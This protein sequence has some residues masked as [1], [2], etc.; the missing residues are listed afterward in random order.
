MKFSRYNVWA[1]VDDQVGLYNGMSGGMAVFSPAERAVVEGFVAGTDSGESAAELLASLVRMR[2]ITNDDV[3]EVAELRHRY[4]TS[5]WHGGN[6]GY[7]VVTSLGCNFDCPYCF[8]D[9]HPSLLKAEVADALVTVLEDSVPF[10][11]GLQVTWMGG[12]PLLGKRQLLDLSDRFLA[13]CAT[14]GLGYRASII[15]NGWYLDGPTARALAE[16]QVTSA[17]VTIDGPP[18]VHDLKRPRVGGGPTFD[19]IVDNIG[20]AAEHLDVAIRVNVDTANVHR[21]DE[22][23]GVLAATGLAGKVGIGLGKVTDAVSNLASPLASYATGCLSAQRFGE[24]ELAFN[25]RA[26]AHGFGYPGLP[27]PRATPCTAVR[28]REIVVGSDGEMWK[29]WDDIGD[30]ARS[31]GTVFD[32]RSTNDELDR[33]M[34]YHPADDPQCSTCIAMPVC[35]GGCA[36]HEFHSDDR[37]ARCGSFR[38]N[39]LDRVGEAL[40]RRL[41]LPA[42]ELP[43]L[44]VGPAALDRQAATTSVPVTLR[45]RRVSAVA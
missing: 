36:H 21:L 9:K 31:I 29:C 42:G 25:A 26:E 8:E 2:A 34:A 6:L 4:D 41:G 40:R 1:E 15:T 28:S 17:Q 12:E 38:H 43:P 39:H 14:H 10:V 20:F 45:P 5:R 16:R 33:W 44:P 11:E 32:Y 3:D 19:R 22:L 23:L 30:P 37:E 27:T 24:V 7:T 13:T 35:M 18:D